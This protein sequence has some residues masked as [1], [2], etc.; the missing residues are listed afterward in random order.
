MDLFVNVN[1]MNLSGESQK[2]EI[3]KCKLDSFAR[4]LFPMEMEM[5]SF[6]NGSEMSF[7]GEI[8]K[9]KISK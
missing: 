3:C 9:M 6:A 2:M 7:S 5:D 1:G 4:E 8:Q